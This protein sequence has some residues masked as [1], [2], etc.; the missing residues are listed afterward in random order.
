MQKAHKIGWALALALAAVQAV[1]WAQAGIVRGQT[2]RGESFLVGGIGADEVSALQ[3][4]HSGYGLSVRTAARGSGAYL[5]DVHLHIADAGGQAV[6]DRNLAG[7]WLL[8]ALRPGRYTLV[9]SHGADMQ[10]ATVT[11]S[12][13]ATHDQMFYFDVAPSASR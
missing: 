1:A 12:A 8:I 3:G 13:G 7:P 4:A 10:T 6:F 5:A 2:A 9:A 11:V